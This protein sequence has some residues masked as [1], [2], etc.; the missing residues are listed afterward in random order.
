[1]ATETSATPNATDQ[2]KYDYAV[3]TCTQ[4]VTKVEQ[5]VT[6]YERLL[7]EDAIELSKSIKEL[8]M[9]PFER[10]RSKIKSQLITIS[11]CGAFS[12]GKSFLISG[13]I[14]RL[15]WYTRDPSTVD[16]FEDQRIDGYATFLPTSPE[17]TNSCPLAVIPLPSDKRSRFE[18]QF[19]DT[20]TWEDKSEP[21]I[22]DDEIYR[23]QLAYATDIDEWRAARPPQDRRRNVVRARLYV[24]GM[25]FPAIM[26]DLPGIGGAGEVYLQAVHEALR[27]ADCI[28]YVASGIKELTD[29]EL[30]L[31]RFVEEISEQNGC[32]VFFLLTQIDREPEWK[33]ILEKNNL[34]LNQY[35][36]K[37][38]RANKALIGK[39]F[40]PVSAG[41]EAKAKGLFAEGKLTGLAQDKAIEKSGMPTLRKLLHEHLTN[42]S[43]PEHLR[44]IAVVTPRGTLIGPASAS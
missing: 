26:H 21:Y 25:T 22:S 28:I 40:L 41:A 31:L 19:D 3:E 24:G 18:V 29:A 1:M 36:T 17:Q 11:V 44:E 27:E 34:F 13:L 43:G 20:N 12:S 7:R 16:I 8:E 30:A 6:A 23:K 35:F 2:N 37:D 33:R 5:L 9:S 15:D 10:A 32:P 4:I 14:D 42:H 39:G 38:G